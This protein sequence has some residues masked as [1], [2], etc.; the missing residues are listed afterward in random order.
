MLRSAARSNPSADR[1]ARQTS[2]ARSLES[3]TCGRDLVLGL[4]VFL[5]QL[6]CDE[7][8]LAGLPEPVEP[9]APIF[10]RALLLVSERPQLVTAEEVGVPGD[11]RRLLRYLFLADADG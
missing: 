11:D 1:V 6:S 10:V 8:A 2:V 9:F 5:R 7:P 4:V 3:D